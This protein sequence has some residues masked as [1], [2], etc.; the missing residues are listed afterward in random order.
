M[1]REVFEHFI[2]RVLEIAN[3]CNDPTIQ[4]DLMKLANELAE[5]I[6]RTS[7]KHG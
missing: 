5:A 1:N 3:R 4:R 2:A 7:T 6:E